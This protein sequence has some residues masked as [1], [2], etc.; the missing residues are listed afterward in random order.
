M[1]GFI[2]H[3]FTAQ[4]TGFVRIIQPQNRITIQRRIG[5]YHRIHLL[6]TDIICYQA[7]L[8]IGHIRCDFHSNRHITLILFGQ[9]S[10]LFFKHPQQGFQSFTKLQGT[11]PRCVRGGDIDRHIIRM[12][13]NRFQAVEVIFVSIFHRG[14]QVFADI[15]TD[16]PLKLTLLHLLNKVMHPFIIEAHT[17]DN[18]FFFRD[19]E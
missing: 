17:V 12:G 15:N 6:I 10:L 19:T 9:A 3:R 16:D 1:R 5:C 2:P 11:Q 13:I 4:P 14:G 8:I 7:D 18:R